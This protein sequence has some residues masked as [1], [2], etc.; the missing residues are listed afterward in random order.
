M[1]RFSRNEGVTAHRIFHLPALAWL[2][3]AIFLNVLASPLS[4]VQV[5]V[6]EGQMVRV[7]LQNVL[8]TENV[9][10]GDLIDFDVA[11]D[12][13]VNNRVVIQKGAVARGKVTQ[14][15]GAG[16]KKA[17]DAS[18][19][20]RLVSVRAV[21]KQ[22]IPLRQTPHKPKKAD[23]RENEFE[24]NSPIPGY[25]ER[26]VGA[27]K[28]REY[29][30]YTD[31][32]TIVDVP[33]TAP[34]AASTGVP[35]AQPNQAGPPTQTLTPPATPAA[36]SVLS[37]SPL[38]GAD[39]ASVEFNSSPNGADIVIDGSFVGNTPSTLRVAPG[40]HVIELRL[41]GYRAWTRTMVVDPGSH[42]SIRPT[43]EKE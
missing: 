42:P 15:K 29:A 14:V 40:R 34:P 36:P 10:K 3:A 8:T 19:S 20:F 26:M 28:G 38:M 24:E 35:T 1:K 5:R 18:V 4:A 6:R 12:V 13:V 2:G 31:T 11:E 27:E 32:P 41:R 21:D 7:K 37:T 25:A 22:E 23:S 17:K 43:L 33:E 30:V 39:P 16:K 9:E